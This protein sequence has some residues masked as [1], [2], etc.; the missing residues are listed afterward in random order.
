MSIH[1]TFKGQQVSWCGWSWVSWGERSWSE[2][3]RASGAMCPHCGDRVG[4][5]VMYIFE[6]TLLWKNYILG[7]EHSSYMR[8]CFFK[9]SLCRGARWHMSR[10]M[11]STSLSS[12]TSG[13]HLQ[14]QKC[15]QNTIWEWTGGPDQGKRIYGTT[16]NSIQ[17]RNEGEK[18][19]C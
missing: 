18:L 13:I 2:G 1:V 11:W 10:W 6:R 15:I 16:Q 17:Q 12:D 19:E 7:F 3:Q 5:C 9:K 8:W 4:V 14:T